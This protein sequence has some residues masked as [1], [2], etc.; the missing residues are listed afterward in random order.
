MGEY[1]KQRRVKVAWVFFIEFYLTLQII[2]GV[3]KRMEFVHPEGSLI[4]CMKSQSKPNDE[5]KDEEDDFFLLYLL[6]IQK[7]GLPEGL[8]FFFKLN[9]ISQ[10]QPKKRDFLQTYNSKELFE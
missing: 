2:S 3:V 1:K 7:K 4:K 5:A 9:N 8:P 10:G 6:H